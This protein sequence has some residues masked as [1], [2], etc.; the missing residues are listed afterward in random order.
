M[1]SNLESAGKVALIT[2]GNSRIG[3]AASFKSL[4]LK[5]HLTANLSHASSLGHLRYSPKT[6]VTYVLDKSDDVLARTMS[7]CQPTIY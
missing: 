2:G 7:S 3:A 5:F 6:S 1:G 4:Y